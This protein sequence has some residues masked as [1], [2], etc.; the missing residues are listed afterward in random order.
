MSEIEKAIELLKSGEVVAIPTETVYGLAASIYSEIGLQKVFSVKERPF[1][2]PLIVHVSDVEMAKPLTSDWS[3]TCQVL[4]DAFWPGPLTLVV[5]KSSEVSDLITSGLNSVGL[6]CPSHPIAKKLIQEAGFPLAAP[7]ANKFK[8][9]SPTKRSHV[10]DEFGDSVFALEGA[11][12]E[13]GIESTVA[14]IF[15]DRIDVYRPG[16]ITPEMISQALAKAGINIPVNVTQSP[17]APGQLKHHYMPK[18]PVVLSWDNKTPNLEAFE[19]ESSKVFTWDLSDS[20]EAPELAARKLYS[21]F[22]DAEKNGKQGILIHL[23]SSYKTKSEW[24]GVLNRLDKAKT[25]EVFP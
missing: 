25:F 6:R 5:P 10:L 15:K 13:I 9:T 23:P 24:A 17:V 18:I 21:L 19:L 7:S 12:S 8:R 1:F 14:G 4:A 3:V 11:D 2:D 22:R 16:M 20:N